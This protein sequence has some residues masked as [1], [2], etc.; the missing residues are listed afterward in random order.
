[1]K[2]A[3][4]KTRANE[5]LLSLPN[6]GKTLAGKLK[7]IGI[8]DAGALIKEGSQNA[9]LKIKSGGGHPCYSMLCALEGAIRNTR[10][11]DLPISIKLELKSFYESVKN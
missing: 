11:H 8:T 5:K 2:V 1:M 3:G 9:F 10:W 4:A 7:A 6:V